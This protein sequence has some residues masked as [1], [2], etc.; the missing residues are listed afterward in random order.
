MNATDEPA[1]HEQTFD[2]E[3][4]LWLGDEP[5]R[6]RAA[7]AER[8]R[9]IAAEFAKGFDALRY[10]R[11]ISSGHCKVQFIT[12]FRTHLDGVLRELIP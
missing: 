4:L 3:L 12:C 2:E 11:N 9:D 1:P 7:D 10:C 5:P 8:V 6:V